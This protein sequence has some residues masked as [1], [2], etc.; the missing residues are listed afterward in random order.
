MAITCAKSAGT[1]LRTRRRGRGRS[2]AAP[3]R[4]FTEDIS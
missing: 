2:R 4:R 3:R 1:A